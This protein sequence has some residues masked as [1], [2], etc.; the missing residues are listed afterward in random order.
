M[1]FMS[2]SS[3]I[4]HGGCGLP[5]NK[6]YGDFMHTTS[7][8]WAVPALPLPWGIAQHRLLGAEGPGS[9]GR[10]EAKGQT[11]GTRL[12]LPE[13][14]LFPTL[15]GHFGLC[16]APREAMLGLGVPSGLRLGA[17]RPGFKY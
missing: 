12:R 1:A 2:I 4:T 8:H 16:P 15:A 11:A 10:L 9:L 13:N 7:L 5:A 6:H 17:R 14:S 3:T